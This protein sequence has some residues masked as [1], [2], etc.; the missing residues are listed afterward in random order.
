MPQSQY[1]PQQNTLPDEWTWQSQ[2]MPPGLTM[3]ADRP[4]TFDP[5][6]AQDP[7][8]VQFDRTR[9]M[10]NPRP[11]DV[12][13]FEQ[14]LSTVGQ[15]LSDPRNAWMGMGP[16]GAVR[17]TP[18]AAQNVFEMLSRVP[19]KFNE[20]LKNRGMGIGDRLSTFQFG[21]LAHD[22]GPGLAAGLNTA[23]HMPST[24]HKVGELNDLITTTPH[25]AEQY[26]H[27]ATEGAIQAN[28]AYGAL[29]RNVGRMLDDMQARRLGFGDVAK[30]PPPKAV[31]AR[32]YYKEYPIEQG[33]SGPLPAWLQNDPVALSH[34]RGAMSDARARRRGR[35]IQEIDEGIERAV[36]PHSVR[37]MSRA[38]RDADRAR[39]GR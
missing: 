17:W 15:V 23:E 13:A 38:E 11:A 14:F 36:Y 28:A 27:E 39:R 22:P 26:R 25:L 3:S 34:Y 19:G 10:D 12:G 4:F 9:T 5:G 29:S 20:F 32:E 37:P 16:V 33:S 35:E 1:V 8:T 31:A 21:N 24:F 2:P 18:K 7:R 6:P 30:T